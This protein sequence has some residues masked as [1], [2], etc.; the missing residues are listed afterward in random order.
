MHTLKGGG[1]VKSSTPRAKCKSTKQEAVGFSFGS[2]APRYANKDE[3]VETDLAFMIKTLEFQP[4][5]GFN[6]AARWAAT[7]AP[8]D[9]RP[10]EIITLPTNAK[11]DAQLQAAT[12]QIEAHG[13]IPNVRLV[14]HNGT[15]YFRPAEPR[16]S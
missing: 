16:G 1:V 4:T 5:R 6:G 12:A 8:Y 7:V 9:G 2:G 11:R 15:F 3:Y 14:K 13:P 10:D